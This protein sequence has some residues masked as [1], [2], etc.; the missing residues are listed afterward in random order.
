MLLHTIVIFVD[1]IY[2]DNRKCGARNGTGTVVFRIEFNGNLFGKTMGVI[3]IPG[4]TNWLRR[5]F[6]IKHSICSK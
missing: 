4:E 1:M 2:S 6:E 3:V 5:N